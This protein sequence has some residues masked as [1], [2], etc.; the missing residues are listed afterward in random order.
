MFNYRNAL[1]I[2][3]A[4]FILVVNVVDAKETWL[5]CIVSHEDFRELN[6]PK[7]EAFVFM[8]DDVRQKLFDYKDGALV[9][10][11]DQRGVKVVVKNGIVR[12]EYIEGSIEGFREINRTTLKFVG[13]MF[14]VFSE[15][16]QCS[17]AQPKQ[18]LKRRF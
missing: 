15:E 18:I 4:S 8:F 1:G 14:H 16:G 9:D 10:E 12:S 13:Y 5:E 6:Q 3:L 11:E 2:M 7:R 17:V